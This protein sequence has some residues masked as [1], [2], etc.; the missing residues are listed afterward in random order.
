VTERRDRRVAII[1]YGLAGRVFHG[2]LVAATPGLTVAAVV[3]SDPGR[4]SQAALAHPGAAILDTPDALWARAGELD[5]VVVAT[6]NDSHA[7]LATAAIDHGLAVVVDK[8]MALGSAEGQA[9][10]D[11]AAGAGVPLTAFQNRRWDS[12]QLTLARLLADGA[13]GT[14]LRFE[15]RFERWRPEARPEVWREAR[16]P[17]QGGGLLLDLGSHLIDQ[18]RHHFGP[19]AEVHAEIAAVRGT[20]AD[21]DA[22]VALTHRNGVIS[23]L[24]ASAV[25]AAPGPRLRVLGTEGALLVRELDTQEDRLRNGER[26]DRVPDWGTEPSFA[27]PRLIAGDRSVP[28]QAQRGDWPAFYARFRD[29]LTGAGPVPVD[30]AD[31]VAVLRVIEAARASAAQR[32]VV[33]LP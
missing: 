24:H 8:P 28:L 18:A 4:G 19:V 27:A 23:H 21:D 7:A 6:P 31:A 17:E 10:V 26:P 1:G 20:A 22:F 5:A 2:P 13:L 25:T 3:T 32:R 33:T 15:S 11:H 14:V 29:A 16:T 12:D 30:P 9:L